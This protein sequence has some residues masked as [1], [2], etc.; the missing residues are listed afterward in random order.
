M[1]LVSRSSTDAGSFMYI[2]M[3][4]NNRNEPSTWGKDSTQVVDT[5]IFTAN[6]ITHLDYR[7]RWNTGALLLH[8]GGV[9][10]PLKGNYFILCQGNFE[11]ID[12]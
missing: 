9:W 6:E 4:F 11:G 1:K 10:G 8:N 12:W 3:W 5:S 2:D 7:H